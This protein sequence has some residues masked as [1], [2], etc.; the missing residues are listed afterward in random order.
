DGALPRAGAGARAALPPDGGGGTVQHRRRGRGVYREARAARARRPRDDPGRPSEPE[1][2]RHRRRRAPAPRDRTARASRD[3]S[4]LRQAR[5]PR[6]VR[7]GGAG[8]G[9]ER[10][11]PRRA[12]SLMAMRDGVPVVAIVGRPNVG[13]STL[14][15]R[16]VRAR[17]A[18]VDDA[19]GVTRDRVIAPAE[20]GGR[21][22]LCVDTGGFAADA[23]RATSALAARVR[24]QTL[25]AVA[26]S[27]CVLCVFDADA[28]LIP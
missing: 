16:L 24:E 9:E 19:P 26:E 2:D 23:S 18:I 25:R 11:A 5:L 27:D 14:F 17:R 6:A 22:F 28:G 13:K 3:G 12:G 21:Q 20:H 15:N 7:P 8:V 1:A 4:T 10:A